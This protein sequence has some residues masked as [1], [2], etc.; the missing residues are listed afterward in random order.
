MV[1]TPENILFIS[2]VLLIL[3]IVASKTAGKAGIPIL[4]LFLAIGILAGSEG[5]GGIYFN[6]PNLTQFLGITALTYILFSGGLDT[7]WQSIKP[8]LGPG[9]VLSTVG[10]LLT[11]VSVGLF[12]HAVSSFSLLEGLLMGAIV[13]STDAAAVFGILR[14]KSIGLKGNLRPMLELESGSNDP[15]AYFLTIGLTSMLSIEQFTFIDLIPV[16]FMQMA[17]G[18]AGGYLLGRGIVLIINRINLEYEGLYPVLM[19]GM[20]AMLYALIDFAGGNGFL[21][22]Y[23]AALAIGNGKMVHK[24]SLIKFFDGVAWLMQIVMFITLGLLVFPSQVMPIIGL[25]ALVSLFLIFVARPLGVFVSLAFFKYKIRD[26][27]FISWVGLRGAVPI[28]FATFPLIA[29]VEKSNIIFNI[30]F[31]IVLTSVALQATT[32]SIMAKWLSLAVPEGL[33]RRS[34]LDLEL[35]EDFKNA[36]V[37]VDL[38]EDSEIGGKKIWELDFPK[39]SL[40]V[41]INRNEKFITPNGLTE[42]KGGDKLLIMMNSENEEHKVKATLGV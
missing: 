16:F 2:S 9:L 7:K 6:D 38:P 12:V 25:G 1:V 42:L 33:K 26:K 21:G 35:S 18:G 28:V 14:A 36:L 30:V 40:I 29:G 39:T 17:I 4:L 3:S 23:V 13:S 24:K 8:V 37:E 10:V 41:L 15:M 31:F 20:V 19:L 22:V 5:I 32:L 27:L 34:L 11:A